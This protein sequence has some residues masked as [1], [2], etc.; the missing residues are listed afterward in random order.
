MRDPRFQ[1]AD[2]ARLQ[3]IVL[4]IDIEE[5]ASF[6]DIFDDEDRVAVPA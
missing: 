1:Y 4:A 6:Y 3:N 2:I 5:L